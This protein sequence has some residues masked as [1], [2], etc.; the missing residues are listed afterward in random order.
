MYTT[1]I[2][3]LERLRQPMDPA[4]GRFVDLYAPLLHRWACRLNLSDGDAADLVQ[5]VFVQL[6]RKLPE[7][8]HDGQHRFRDWLR[9]VLVN[10]YRDRRVRREE[11]VPGE[12]DKLAD[13][14]A[15]DPGEAAAAAEYRQYLVG[16]ALE[17]MQTDFEPATWKA[18][19]E[20]TVQGRPAAEVAAE[21]G[22]SVAAVYAATARVL[23]RLREELHG[24]WE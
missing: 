17:L 14:D 8:R 19:W 16:R 15:P 4:W 18:C 21:L 11:P 13:P 20:T 12:L 1:S 3:L 23:R 9:A 2:S 7:F 10:Q 22:L 24:F 5:D 6:V